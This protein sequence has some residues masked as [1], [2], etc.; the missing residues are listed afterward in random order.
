[1]RWPCAQASRS[2][3]GIQGAGRLEA[4]GAVRTLVTAVSS[5]V[6][7]RAAGEAGVSYIAPYVGR[8]SDWHV[9]AQTQGGGAGGTDA[10]VLLVQDIVREYRARGFRT[11]VMAASLRTK[12]QIQALLGCDIFT[13][14][15]KLIVDM[16]CA[17]PVAGLEPLGRPSATDSPLPLTEQ[18]FRDALQQDECGSKVFAN[19]MSSFLADMK[20]LEQ[21]FQ[22]Y[23]AFV[24]TQRR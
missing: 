17:E 4:E 14:S 13:L 23:V 9:Q 12:G 7:A 18:Q 3:E 16:E 10:G 24:E 5:R 19:S 6:Q 2:W 22:E 1:M 11:K 20:R 8:V 21:I 15:P